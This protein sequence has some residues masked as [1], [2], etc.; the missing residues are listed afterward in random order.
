MRS[1]RMRYKAK[2]LLKIKQKYFLDISII[3]M[4]L[5]QITL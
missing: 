4:K 1:E 5:V 2:K 3:Y